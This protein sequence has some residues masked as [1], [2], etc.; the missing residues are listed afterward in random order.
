M[1]KAL[2]SQAANYGLSMNKAEDVKRMI[3]SLNHTLDDGTGTMEEYT[4]QFSK[5]APAAASA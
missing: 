2:I 3:N 1:Q 5:V 4:A